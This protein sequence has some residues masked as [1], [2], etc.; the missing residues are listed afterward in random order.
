VGLEVVSFA[1][2]A[3][4]AVAAFVIAIGVKPFSM[5]FLV[6]NYYLDLNYY[7]IRLE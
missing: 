1:S 2:V 7:L 6:I 5:L 4:A 3:V